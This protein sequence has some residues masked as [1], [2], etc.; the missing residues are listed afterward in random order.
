MRALQQVPDQEESARRSRREKLLDP[1]DLPPA[2][3]GS[4]GHQHLEFDP[5]AGALYVRC[6]GCPA[7]WMAVQEHADV[8]DYGQRATVIRNRLRSDPLALPYRERRH[9]R[10]GPGRGLN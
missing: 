2:V 10:P 3:V 6:L 4:C 5:T 8:P 7:R 1:F 9:P